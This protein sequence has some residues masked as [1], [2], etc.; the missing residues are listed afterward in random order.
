MRLRFN[1]K[2]VLKLTLTFV[3]AIVFDFIC[4]VIQEC[5]A[6]DLSI[7]G[8]QVMLNSEN[9]DPSRGISLEAGNLWR[10]SLS[11]EDTLLR[12]GGQ[13]AC[14]VRLYG[15]AIVRRFQ[16]GGLALDLGGGY[17]IPEVERRAPFR[18]GMW[19]EI[20]HI[21]PEGNHSSFNKPDIYEYELHGNIGGFF[22]VSY[23]QYLTKRIALYFGGG[24]RYLKLQENLVRDHGAYRPGSWVE[25]MRWQD[26]GGGFI[27]LGLNFHF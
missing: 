4:G 13:E 23:E 5:H 15:L 26:L 20:N 11:F 10:V 12:F 21:Y 14:D 6:F 22:R 16:V 2:E 27:A 8:N 24:Y 9:L 19:L 18:E 3:L 17:F 1:E 25:F 7:T